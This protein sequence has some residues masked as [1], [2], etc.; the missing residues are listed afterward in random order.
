MSCSFAQP[1]TKGF[2]PGV[3]TR[4]IL[5]DLQKSFDTLDYDILLEKMKYLGFSS[6]AIDWFGS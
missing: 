3:S 5:I 6:K 4:M 1:Y 2:E